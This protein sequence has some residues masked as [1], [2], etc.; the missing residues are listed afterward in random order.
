[1]ITLN[2]SISD[3]EYKQYGLKNNQLTFADILDIANREMARQTLTECVQLAEKYGLSE[4]TMDE[5]TEEVK[6]ARRDA[7]ARH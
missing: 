6:A 4:M 2:V 3:N 7:K 5:I 1:M